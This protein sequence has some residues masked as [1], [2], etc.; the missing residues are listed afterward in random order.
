MSNYTPPPKSNLPFNFETGGYTAPD[1]GNLSANFDVK[2]VREQMA[3]LGAAIRVFDTKQETYTY[4]KYCEE[5]VVG[6]TQAGVQIIRGRCYFGGIRDIGGFIRSAKA[7]TA[8][9]G[10]QLLGLDS[11]IEVNL[12]AYIGIHPYYGLSAF[13]RGMVSIGFPAFI[14]G[15]IPIDLGAVI[16]IIPPVDLLGWIKARLYDD[17][18]AHVRGW[19]TADLGA[20]I[21]RRYK[22]DLRGVI[23]VIETLTNLPGV[24]RGWVREA[25]KDLPAQ[26]HG[27]IEEYLPGFIR[28]TEY[29]NLGARLVYIQPVPLA[30]RIHGWQEAYLQGIIDGQEWPW[31]LPASIYGTGSFVNLHAKIKPLAEVGIFKNLP[32]YIKIL[33]ETHDLPSSLH[34]YQNRDLGAFLNSGKDR[35][36]LLAEIYP[37]MIRL[38]AILSIV[39]ME[40]K[41]LIGV[42]NAACIKSDFREIS[43]YIRPM[44]KSDL[45]AYI[46]A[47]YPVHQY[48]LNA[49]IGHSEK[50]ITIDKLPINV[51]IYSSGYRTEDKLQLVFQ[52]LKSGADLTASIFGEYQKKDLQAIINVQYTGAYDFTYWN[53]RERVFDLHFGDMVNYKDVDIDFETIVSDYLYSSAGN[54][55]TRTNINEHWRTR[56]MSFYSYIDYDRTLKRL[57]KVKIL[58]DLHKFKSIDEAIKYGIDYVTTDFYYDLTAGITPIGMKVDLSAFVRGSKITSTKNNLTSSINGVIQQDDDEVILSAVDDIHTIDI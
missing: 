8:D 5:Y 41:D 4:L 36:D 50:Y 45:P 58:F 10:A 9:L 56:L 15:V 21:D 40:R 37:K 7:S 46:K 30:A 3:T 52:L 43:A 14:T 31:N 20:Y 55:V 19:Q 51:Y 16:D 28:G 54:V 39:T 33:R 44:Y 34:V 35:K 47:I 11:T 13:I 48:D 29:R 27:Y 2:T 24:I 57:Y 53:K 17:L 22:A 23:G 26:V 6:Y 12:P 25:Y 42:I 18:P 32:A 38:T 49:T 1:F